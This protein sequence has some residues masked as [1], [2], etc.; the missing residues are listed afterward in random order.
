MFEDNTNCTQ[1]VTSR[2]E[3]KD[4]MM[5]NLNFMMPPKPITSVH[6]ALPT[7][8]SPSSCVVVSVL[9]VSTVHCIFASTRVIQPTVSIECSSSCWSLVSW[10]PGPFKLI[11]CR[12]SF[13]RSWDSII[14]L[15]SSSILF[16]GIIGYPRYY[17]LLLTLENIWI[18]Y[19]QGI[20]RWG[21]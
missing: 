6:R 2:G 16:F 11:W 10:W 18:T 9:D 20:A 4:A 12:S 21:R 15:L 19:Q 7:L 1:N 3:V 17:G 8:P 14:A 13:Q 5:V